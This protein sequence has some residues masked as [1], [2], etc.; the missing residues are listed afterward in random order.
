MTKSI[1]VCATCSI[2][3]IFALSFSACSS[4]R[5]SAGTTEATTAGGISSS[6]LSPNGVAGE[7]PGPP[8]EVKAYRPAANATNKAVEFSIPSFNVTGTLG[9]HPAPEGKVFLVMDTV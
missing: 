9:S 7:P 1:W 4:C 2:V 6:A 5:H 8:L 3:L